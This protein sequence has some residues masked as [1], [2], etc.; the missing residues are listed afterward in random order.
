MKRTKRSL[1]RPRAADQ[2]Q[3][4]SQIIIET[5]TELFL[6]YGYQEVSVDDIAGECNV[7]KATVYYHFENKP[8][9]FT[10]TIVQMMRRISY[11]MEKILSEEI[12]L[13]ERLYHVSEAHLKATVDMDID[14]FMRETKN[15]LA[16]E[17][18]RRIHQAEEGMYKVLEAAFDR[19]MEEREIPTVNPTFAAHTYIA[20]VKAGNYRDSEG[21]AFYPTIEETA[22][23]LTNLFWNGLFASKN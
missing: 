22:A 23:E 21:R 15:A 7:T 20:L 12:P 19:A 4:T 3:P 8:E 17:Q 10:E 5:A 14:G 2:K 18:V 6:S 9:L 16:E 1:G 11:Y 13:F